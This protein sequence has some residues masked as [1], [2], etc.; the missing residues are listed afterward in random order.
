MHNL[1][2][3]EAI[4]IAEAL[5]VPSLALSPCLVPQAPP[6]SFERHF[7]REHPALYAAL[8]RP[9]AAHPHSKDAVWRG[10]AR[11]FCASANDHWRALG[12]PPASHRCA[13]I[14]HRQRKASFTG[15]ALCRGEGERTCG[16]V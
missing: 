4:S 3:M 1:F 15:M 8:T 12:I 13:S 5:G 2:A 9:G 6:A 7:K 11:H 14:T 16:M 10:V